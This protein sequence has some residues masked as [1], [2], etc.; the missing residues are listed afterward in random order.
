MIHF[1]VFAVFRKD[2]EPLVAPVLQ[3]LPDTVASDTGTLYGH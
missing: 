1:T 3:H 2:D